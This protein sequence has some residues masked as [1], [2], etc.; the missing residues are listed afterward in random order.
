MKTGIATER[1]LRDNWHKLTEAEHRAMD[2]LLLRGHRARNLN[3]LEEEHRTPGQRLADNVTRQLGSWRFIIIQSTILAAW[4]AANTFAWI[5]NWDP[6]PFILL[7]LALSFQAAY[8]APIIMMSQNREAAKD[9][10]RA[11]EDYHVNL[12]AELDV[13]AIHERLDDLSGRQWEALIQI[14]GEQLAVLAR[15]ESLTAEIHRKTTNAG[16]ET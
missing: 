11:E 1:T 14:Q 6:Y 8:A 16:V 7:N 2:A 10:L 15:I 3:Q 5:R 13:K 12:R 9:R 4:I